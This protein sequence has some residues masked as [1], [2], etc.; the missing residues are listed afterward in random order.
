MKNY[1]GISSLKEIECTGS[2]L[3]SEVTFLSLTLFK[4]KSQ[5]PRSGIEPNL[6]T[7][8]LASLLTSENTCHTYGQFSS[9]VIQNDD[10]RNSV[11]NTLVSDLKEGEMITIGCKVNAVF[12]AGQNQ[13][14]SEFWYIDVKRE[15]KF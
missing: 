13:M 8:T 12:K 14:F 5:K 4:S 9:C 6:Q 1:R 15:S 3:P 11:V 7:N 10:R 2:T